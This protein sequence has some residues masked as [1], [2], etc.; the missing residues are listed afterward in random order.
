MNLKQ[1]Y[2]NILNEKLFESNDEET[3]KTGAQTRKQEKEKTKTYVETRR[4]EE[5]DR[6]IKEAEERKR[7]A[8]DARQEKKNPQFVGPPKP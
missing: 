3:P 2:K 6:K 7:A 1:Y 8:F 4:R 5:R